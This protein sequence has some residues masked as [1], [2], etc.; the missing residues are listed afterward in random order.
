MK[1]CKT[2][3]QTWA[4]L[5]SVVLIL[6]VSFASCQSGDDLQAEDENPAKVERKDIPLTKAEE[7]IVQ[8]NN[9]FGFNLL[10]AI[11]G[12][13]EEKSNIFIS[14]LSAS[15]ALGMLNNGAAGATSEE[16]RSAL[17]Y[18]DVS[19]EDLNGYFK[20]MLAAMTTLDPE[21]TLESA[22]SI[23]I[24]DDF[25]VLPAFIE[26]NQSSYDATVSHADFSDPATLELI[27]G[28]CAEKTH[29]KIDEILKDIPSDA[30]LYLL[31]ALYFKGIWIT[32]FDKDRTYD[33]TFAN[34]NGATPI[35][36]MMRQ[37]LQLNYAQ[38]D[39]AEMVEVPYGNEAFSMVFV[40]PAGGAT[41]SGVVE[42]LAS[43]WN[44]ISGMSQQTVDLRVPRMEL[45]Y[46]I[47]IIPALK[48]LGMVSMFSNADLSGINSEADLF[49]SKVK[50]KTTLDI[51]EEGAEAAA[52][53]LVEVTFSAAHGVTPSPISFTLNRPFLVFIKEKSTGAILF[54]GL[55]REF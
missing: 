39:I 44:T 13:E 15:L 52:V 3:N 8:G 20:K 4:W 23:W 31:N 19:T 47:D 33:A 6:S 2:V 49:V 46:E 35:V 12:D 32:S 30:V 34:E 22:N 25:Q 53:T 54:E 24:R 36:P 43:M 9:A 50:Q 21:V 26:V 38:N 7:T 14:P 18:K 42:N 16:I 37:E 41:L 27:N 17:G 48:K 51:N 11:S 40:L 5:L 10:Q 45:A 29:G 28:W 1:K 55:I